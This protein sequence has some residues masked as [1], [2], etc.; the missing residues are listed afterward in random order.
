MFWLSQVNRKKLN[1]RK[2]RRCNQIWTIQRHWQHWSHKRYDENNP[3][4]LAT[5]IIQEIWRKQSRDTGNIGHTRD[6]TKTIQ[7]HWQHW[8]HKRYEENNPE[9]LATLIT[10]EI[11]RK[12]SRDTDNIGHTRDMTKTLVTQE[13]WRKQTTNNNKQNTTRLR[14]IMNMVGITMVHHQP[15][16]FT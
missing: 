15:I 5:L 13:I 3:E 14:K 12:Q 4:T 6:M 1:V 11:W 8:S 9:T 10:Q 7:K 16:L 2:N